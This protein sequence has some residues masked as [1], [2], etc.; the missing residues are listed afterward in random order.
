MPAC[1]ACGRMR[2]ADGVVGNC[3]RSR[4]ARDPCRVPSARCRHCSRLKIL[5][6]HCRAAR[7]R[8]VAVGL[9]EF[10]QLENQGPATRRVPG[11]GMRAYSR[12]GA[13]GG[14]HRDQRG[15][16][17]RRRRGAGFEIIDIRTGEEVAARPAALI[18]D[19]AVRHIPMHDLLADPGLLSAGRPA[20]LVC[21]SGKRSLA[22]ARVLR[23]RGLAV[24]SLA[25]GLQNLER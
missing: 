7:W 17:G 5:L 21:A 23:Q 9:H 4:R 22:A 3:A 12:S 6:Q 24:R 2:L 11:A 8:A 25:G 13:R 19:T 14:R 16:A 10:L 20:L 1:V 18:A 15:F